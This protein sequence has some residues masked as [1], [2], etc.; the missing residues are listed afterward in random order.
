MFAGYDIKSFS[1]W[2]EN[3]VNWW[4]SIWNPEPVPEE[5]MKT[6][7]EVYY[8]EEYPETVEPKK[9]T[10]WD[11]IRE[12]AEYYSVPANLI[13]AIIRV[14]SNF[15]PMAISRAGARGLMQLLPST[16]RRLGYDPNYL[17]DPEYNID[18]GARYL[19]YLI[20]RYGYTTDAIAAY[21]VGKPIKTSTG[22][23]VNQ[24]YVER[25]VSNL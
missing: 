7:A 22:E 23:Y 24:D 16:A 13:T 2:W 8:D 4:N 3:L 20:D 10:I 9:K 1:G 6:P 14:E 21:N 11:I 17:L 18:A 25:V 19:R 12:K 15:N 5:T